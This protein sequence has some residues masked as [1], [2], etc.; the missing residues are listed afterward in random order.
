MEL[1]TNEWSY[2]AATPIL[3][4]VNFK[5]RIGTSS[6]SNLNLIRTMKQ[7]RIV[8]KQTEEVQ[9]ERRHIDGQDEQSLAIALRYNNGPIRGFR[10]QRFDT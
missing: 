4:G 6:A 8:A 2:A 10:F 5:R 1:W 3:R 9:H 7:P